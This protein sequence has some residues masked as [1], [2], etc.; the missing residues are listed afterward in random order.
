MLLLPG[1]EHRGSDHD[2]GIVVGGQRVRIVEEGSQGRGT[3]W[4]V[5]DGSIVL[6]R[7]FEA[8]GGVIPKGLCSILELGAGTGLAGICTAVLF[9]EAQVCL[10]DIDDALPALR[11]N[12]DINRSRVGHRVSV[13][14][15]DWTRPS[16]SI[17]TKKPWDIVLATDVVWLEELVEPFIDT[18]ARI[19]KINPECS[20]FMS[21]QS[22]TRRVDDMLFDGLARKHFSA[23]PVP[24]VDNEPPRK[25]IEIFRV[26]A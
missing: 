20:I 16:D 4:C 5:W 25:K 22:R 3:A 17:V 7:Y 19:A 12:V 24:P 10:T 23:V 9:P 15:C 2:G 26:R 18:L 6:V 14:A 21:Y 13:E 11:T 1:P 8:D